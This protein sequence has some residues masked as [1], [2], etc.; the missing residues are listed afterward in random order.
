MA[1]IEREGTTKVSEGW[2]S[3]WLTL[4]HLRW[5]GAMA[6]GVVAIV[7][8][9]QVVERWQ[10]V[11]PPLQ[12]S[13]DAE[14]AQREIELDSP[15]A[16]EPGE[17]HGETRPSLKKA[18]ADTEPQPETAA[19]PEP[20]LREEI[21]VAEVAPEESPA[22][23]S[24][25]APAV[26]RPAAAESE[27]ERPPRS[28]PPVAPGTNPG[29]ARRDKGGIGSLAVREVEEPHALPMASIPE[30][31]AVDTVASKERSA[32]VAVEG[33][34]TEP[35]DEA[36][37][38]FAALERRHLR[39]GK[40]GLRT[41][42][43]GASGSSEL[44]LLEMCSH[45]RDYIEKYPDSVESL[46]AR[47]RLAKCSIDLCNMRPTEE[48]RLQAVEDGESFAEAAPEDERVEEI[49]RLIRALRETK[50]N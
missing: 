38:A 14:P 29:R 7:I 1:R 16:A 6:A 44:E 47:Y 35:N 34:R 26:A 31:Q 28:A 15:M 32:E 4:S 17:I 9:L 25:E 24:L 3:S 41:T 22:R 46:E 39:S 23:M 12:P 36:R 42:A 13:A 20:K 30:A 50:E 45:W 49:N 33:R 40:H 2:I 21:E 11:E 37:V 19:T 27:P 18:A 5:A 8:G 48:M 43:T 10:P